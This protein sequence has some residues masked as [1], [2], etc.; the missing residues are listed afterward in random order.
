MKRNKG[1]LGFGWAHFHL[2]PVYPFTEDCSSRT[3]QGILFQ[4]SIRAQVVQ[5]ANKVYLFLRIY[6]YFEVEYT[7]ARSMAALQILV[8]LTPGVSAT[9]AVHALLRL[10]VMSLEWLRVN[11]SYNLR[12]S[13][14]SHKMHICSH[15]VWQRAQRPKISDFLRQ[16]A[17]ISTTGA[18]FRVIE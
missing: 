9:W 14:S 3:A 1:L 10:D 18:N 4:Q 11:W 2:M 8:L 12:E 15:F 16:K 6:L 17:V 5:N 13:R 7:S